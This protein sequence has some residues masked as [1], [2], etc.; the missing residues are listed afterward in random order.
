MSSTA[1]QPLQ[2]PANW[3][4]AAFYLCDLQ[5]RA[6]FS[7]AEWTTIKDWLMVTPFDQESFIAG[8]CG[9]ALIRDHAPPELRR[10]IADALSQSNLLPRLKDLLPEVVEGTQRFILGKNRT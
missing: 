8:E 10:E 3:A 7:S 4:S 9:L 1:T 2:I 5:H 6:P